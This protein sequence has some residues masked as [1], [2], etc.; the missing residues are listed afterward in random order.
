[1]AVDEPE[2]IGVI[3]VADTTYP[4]DV[5]RPFNPDP[6]RELNRTILAIGSFAL[7]AVVVLMILAAVVLLGKSWQDIEPI[8]AVLL[9]AVSALTSTT[10]AFFF[11]IER[12]RGR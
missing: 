10:L 2:E 5:G 8:A 3:R 11:V 9:P 12:H 7:F 1:M 4:V 6:V